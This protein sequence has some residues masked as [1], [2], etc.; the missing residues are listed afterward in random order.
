LIFSSAPLLKYLALTMMGYPGRRP[1]PV[2][3]KMPCNSDS[4][5]TSQQRPSPPSCTTVDHFCDTC[6]RLQ[7]QRSP[8]R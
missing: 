1:L 3:L 4:V 7:P 5:S 6:S 8:S 2:T